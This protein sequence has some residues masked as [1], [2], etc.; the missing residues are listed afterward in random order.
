MLVA[1][2]GSGYVGLVCRAC[3]TYRS[4]GRPPIEAA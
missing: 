1:T 2:I 3:F 4:V